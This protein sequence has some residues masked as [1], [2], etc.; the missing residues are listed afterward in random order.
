M[1][2]EYMG[3]SVEMLDRFNGR[4]A[5]GELAIRGFANMGAIVAVLLLLFCGQ[6]WA[7]TNYVSPTGT[8][9]WVDCEVTATPC[10]I[11]TAQTS[12]GAGDIIILMDGTYTTGI[13]TANNGTSGAGVITW[14]AQNNRRAILNGLA[15]GATD[16]VILVDNAY[17]IFDG[18]VINVQTGPGAANTYGLFVSAATYT[19]FK[20]GEITFTGDE[21]T[22]G[23]GNIAYCAQIRSV[24]VFTGNYVHNCTYGLSIFS[25]SASFVP[26]V[27]NN[28]FENMI[29][30]DYEDSDCV[31]VS[32]AASYDWVGLVLEDNECSGYRDDGFDMSSQD[33]VVIQDNII[34]GPIN[35]VAENSS[36]I[37]AGYE[38]SNGTKI[39]R[40]FCYDI[41]STATNRN[42]GIVMTGAS[43]ALAV[44]NIFVGGYV[45]V[46]ISQ[47]NASGGAD[48]V[49]RNNVFSGFSRYGTQIYTGATGTILQNNVFDGA[50]Y[51]I[52]VAS[53][54]TATGYTN[55]MVNALNSIVGTYNQ[56]GDTTGAPGFRSASND[57]DSASDFRLAAGS[58]LRRLG[59][60]LNL[61]NIQ[62]HGNRAF[63]HPPSCGAWEAASGDAATTRTAR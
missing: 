14:Q 5:P 23:T 59:T 49:V 62:D 11:A 4:A 38:G 44:G 53:G 30:G 32:G 40:N 39:Y 31:A 20:N 26:T 60:D 7:T 13:N 48:N 43:S 56:T 46:D 35:D 8:A 33:N 21:A 61:G 54:L 18:I 6:A 1:C 25:S 16:K 36:C 41:A 37:K 12:G 27:N 47:R 24:T 45:G 22:M 10:S 28:T 42:Y 58:T 57:S 9:A 52:L 3:G 15:S 34:H 29:V 63:M 55:R 19:E 17:H 50:V 51:D 2:A